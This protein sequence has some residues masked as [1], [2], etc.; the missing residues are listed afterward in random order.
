MFKRTV[1]SDILKRLGEPRKFIQ[2]LAGPR[3][4][5]DAAFGWDFEKYVCFGGYPGAVTLIDDIDRWTHYRNQYLQ[6]Y[7][8]DDLR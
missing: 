1:F 4:L 5:M 3:Q 7:S 8:A 6:G 2:V